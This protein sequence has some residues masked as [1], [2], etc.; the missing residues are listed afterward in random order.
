MITYKINNKI[1]DVLKNSH[2]VPNSIGLFHGEIG[3]CFALYM[4]NKRNPSEEYVKYADQLLDNILIKV[5]KMS[6]PAFENGI[7]GVG[8]VINYLH[9]TN[10]IE[11]DIDDILFQIDATVFKII[12]DDNTKITTHLNGLI[13]YLGYVVERLNNPFHNENSIL[14]ELCA[15][16]LRN[17]I[18]RLYLSMP[19][20]LKRINEDI[21]PTMLWDFPILFYFLRLA[22]DSNVYNVKIHH[23]MDYL[24]FYICSII[25]YY[26]LNKIV[27][28][29]SL[30]FLNERLNNKNI[31]T[32]IELLYNAV[33]YSNITNEIDRHLNTFYGGWCNAIIN[34]TIAN[35]YIA[36]DDIHQKINSTKKIIMEFVKKNI[37][38]I[39]TQNSNINLA[40]GLSGISLACSLYPKAF[41]GL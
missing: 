21:Y 25:P 26:D 31:K 41:H 16:M 18:D 2:N 37:D 14:H 33:D 17:I 39:I 11:G 15:S 32:H 20:A 19:N 28:A 13:G 29:N 6:N 5:H 40:D 35:K 24:D 9:K 23:T 10:C 8:Y 12:N 30:S 27:L 4:A 34:L 36:N 3:I 1:L 38:M 7:A 22:L